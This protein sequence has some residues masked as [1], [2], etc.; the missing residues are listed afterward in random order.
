MHIHNN[1]LRICNFANKICDSFFQKR[2]TRSHI[3][4]TF[5]LNLN[6]ELLICNTFLH[7]CIN[8][9]KYLNLITHMRKKQS[10]KCIDLSGN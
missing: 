6:M 2:D 1:L 8:L 7:I 5:H 10:L 4:K 9:S 3:C